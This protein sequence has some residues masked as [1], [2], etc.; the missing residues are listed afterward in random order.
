MIKEK[1]LQVWVLLVLCKDHD[2]QSNSTF[3]IHPCVFVLENSKRR[4]GSIKFAHEKR[5]LSQNFLPLF[6]PFLLLDQ[7]QQ[8]VAP[9]FHFCLQL[10]FQIFQLHLEHSQR[11]YHAT[12]PAPITMKNIYKH[13]K[14]KTMHHILKKIAFESTKFTCSISLNFSLFSSSRATP[15]RTASLI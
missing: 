8:Q 14:F 9:L 3:G 5:E 7:V 4:I 15:L 13:E 10:I 2:L 6:W 11:T 1:Y 12:Q